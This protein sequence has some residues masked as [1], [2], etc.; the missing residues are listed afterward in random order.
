[1]VAV[2]AVDINHYKIYKYVIGV[3]ENMLIGRK[4]IENKVHTTNTVKY[5]LFY[6]VFF[7][8][9]FFRRARPNF[10]RILS[11][12]LRNGLFFDIGILILAGK[13]RVLIICRSS[14]SHVSMS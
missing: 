5:H 14:V 2:S 13:Y 8:E 4:T 6:I 1:M 11:A 3:S 10:P 12:F 9:L 7:G